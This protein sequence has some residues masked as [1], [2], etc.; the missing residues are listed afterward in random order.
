MRIRNNETLG[1]SVIMDLGSIV[2]NVAG[3]RKVGDQE[4]ISVTPNH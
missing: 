3:S 4:A 1:V 2:D